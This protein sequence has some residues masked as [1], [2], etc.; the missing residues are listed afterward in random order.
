MAFVIFIHIYITVKF[1]H[2]QGPIGQGGGVK[3]NCFFFTTYGPKFSR[4]GIKIFRQG[5]YTL[6]SP[7]LVHMYG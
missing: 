3:K 4:G 6:P 1:L 7:P 5:G 2:V